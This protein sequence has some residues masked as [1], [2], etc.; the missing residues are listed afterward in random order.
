MNI[1]HTLIP[2]TALS[3]FLSSAVWADRPSDNKNRDQNSN[4]QSE[5][6]ST[7]GKERAEE[8]HE[9]NKLRKKLKKHKEKYKR[10][11][12]DDR[13]DN[14]THRSYDRDYKPQKRIDPQSPVDQ[15]YDKAKAKIDEMHRKAID[16]LERKRNASVSIQ[17]NDKQPPANQKKAPWWWPFGTSN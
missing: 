17:P 7:R 13:D 5:D 12:D 11:D 3:I 16:E 6:Y 9:M 10:D 1:K 8:R 15:G 14:K 4:R 2:I